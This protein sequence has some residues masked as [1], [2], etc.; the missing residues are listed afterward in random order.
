MYA[1][2]QQNSQHVMVK[3]KSKNKEMLLNVTF[4]WS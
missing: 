1:F 4:G 2:L 3:N